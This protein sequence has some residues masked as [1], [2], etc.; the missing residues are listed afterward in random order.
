MLISLFNKDNFH[1]ENKDRV[2]L[3]EWLS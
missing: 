1:K 3:N 2:K